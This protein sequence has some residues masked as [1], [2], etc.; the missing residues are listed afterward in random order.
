MAEYNGKQG[1]WRT[2]GGRKVFIADG[3]D[4]ATA[5]QNSGK[6]E[7]NFT[8]SDIKKIVDYEYG[9]QAYELNG[10]YLSK[11]YGWSTR[12]NT[13]ICWMLAYTESYS[14]P[15]EESKAMSNKEAMLVDSYKE[16]I[17]K[18]IEIA[19]DKDLQNNKKVKK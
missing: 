12:N 2:I 8:K 5:M 6:F 17:E 13:P 7:K 14:S 10:V 18:L 16:G 15:F 3:E 9:V 4:L 11:Y 1:V 19:N